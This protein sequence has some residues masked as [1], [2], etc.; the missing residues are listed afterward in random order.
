M[1]TNLSIYD[2]IL[3]IF[4]AMIFG[5]ICGAFGWAIG[6]LA[7]YPLVTGLAAH[8]PFYRMLGISTSGMEE[9]HN[10]GARKKPVMHSVR[11]TMRKMEG[12]KK[13]A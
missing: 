6:V 4:I 10:E 8:D 7:V 9:H 5:G 3:R 12:H 11:P 1:K 2:S 13:S